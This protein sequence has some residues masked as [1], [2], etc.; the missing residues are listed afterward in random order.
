[1]KKYSKILLVLVG[2]ILM[3][4]NLVLA[5]EINPHTSESVEVN[6]YEN[7]E[8]ETEYS[9][10]GNSFQNN[11]EVFRA[12][13]IEIIEER[14][15]NGQKQQN[16]KLIGLSG[17]FKGEEFNFQGIDDIQVDL[18]QE[19]EIGNKV[20]VS[21]DQD[22]SGEN[23]FYIIDFI[24]N[25][26]IYFLIGIFCLLILLIAGRKG[27]R[28]LVSLVVTF[29]I[30]FKFILPGILNGY[31]PIL[32]SIS[33]G[34]L[35]LFFVV[36]ITE[37]INRKSHLSVLSIFISLFITGLLAVFFSNLMKLSGMSEDGVYLI[38]LIGR[39]INFKGLLLASV[40]I[41]GLGVLDDMVITQ[42]ST[43]LEIKKASPNLRHKDIFKKAYRVGVSHISSMTNTLFLAYAGSSLTILLLFSVGDMNFSDI[44]N[45]H[46]I[47]T[48]I[49]RSFIGGI[50]IALAMPIS[51]FLA[52]HHLKK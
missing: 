16:L 44:L 15:F 35:I 27:F 29:L 39:E 25:D 1:M 6:L 7:L 14:E 31:N 48:E 43:V 3:V 5:Q 28:S 9:L 4:P 45:N 42:V 20:M 18:S 10:E 8:P 32:I 46:L 33:G 41:G 52:A 38:T 47:A 24:R 26:A 17:T 2:I 51:T 40:I 34:F 11:S 50:G 30:I 36:Y 22:L 37:G 23:V 13:V 19:Y 21:V 12:K 49:F